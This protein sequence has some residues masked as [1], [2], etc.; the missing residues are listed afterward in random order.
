V[1]YLYTT[2]P[3][4]L[5][6][7]LLLSTQPDPLVQENTYLLSFIY[8]TAHEKTQPFRQPII[9]EIPGIFAALKFASVYLTYSCSINAI[10]TVLSYS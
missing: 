9:H 10:F 1:L 8:E 7:E 6:L 5:A 3:W 4:I 2:V